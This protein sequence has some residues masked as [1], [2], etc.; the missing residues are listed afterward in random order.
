MSQ[1]R[2]H[3]NEKAQT[4]APGDPRK[5]SPPFWEW[6]AASVGLLLV[7]ASLGYLTYDAVAATPDAPAP[8]IEVIAV[9]QQDSR[10]LVRVRVH[11]RARATAEGLRITGLLKRNG[12]VVESTEAEFRYLPGRSWREGGLFFSRDPAAFEL[13]L[14]PKGYQKP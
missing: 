2:T 8:A 10:Y 14:G 4:D 11:N 7:V 9:K 12:E 1:S 3:D 5:D 6:V 13:E